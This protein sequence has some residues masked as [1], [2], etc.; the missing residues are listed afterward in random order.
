MQPDEEI[1][2]PQDNFYTITWESD[3]GEK[4]DKRGTE[5]TPTHLPNGEW[6]SAAE[7]NSSDSHENGANF[8]ITRDESN[9]TDRAAHSR[10]ERLGDDVTERNESSEAARNEESD[11]PNPAVYPKNQEKSLPNT[12]EGLKNVENFSERNLM[13][14]MMQTILQTRGMIL[15]CQKYRKTLIEMKT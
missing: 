4:L 12:D 1:V 5:P 13:K 10:N 11:W 6:P 8:I 14:E 9:H 2:I 15:S 3:F 7:T